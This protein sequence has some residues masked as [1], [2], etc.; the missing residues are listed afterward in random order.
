MIQ[1]SLYT[2]QRYNHRQ[3]NKLMVTKG[4]RDQ[5]GYIGNLGLTVKPYYYILGWAKSSFG[6]FH[7]IL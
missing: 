7:K 1:M 5:E 2:K 4:E 3:R 6:F